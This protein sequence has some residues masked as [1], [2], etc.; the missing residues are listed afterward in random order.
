[1]IGPAGKPLPAGGLG[2]ECGDRHGLVAIGCELPGVQAIVQQNVGQVREVG[3]LGEPQPEVVVLGRRYL[4]T[5][6]ADI[7]HGLPPE[8]HRRMG[9]RRGG[10]EEPAGGGRRLWQ[11]RGRG[12]AGASGEKPGLRPDGGHMRVGV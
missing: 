12:C 5:V 4:R 2:N 1:M 10:G 8:H 11:A 3:P 7:E 9:E 6:E